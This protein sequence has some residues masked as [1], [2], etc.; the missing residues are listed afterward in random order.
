MKDK[1]KN[2]K[3]RN[4]YLIGPMGAGK[5][6]VGSRLA[7][8]LK[9]QFYDSDQVIEQQT[10][11]DI[12]WIYDV[13]GED[14]FQRREIK[15]IADLTKLDCILLST[16]GGSVMSQENRAAL[17]GNGV[18]IYLKTSLDNQM[19]RVKR[20]K[21]RPLVNES[22]E[23][24]DHLRNLRVKLGV[25]YEDLADIVYETDG[26]SLYHVVSDIVKILKNQGLI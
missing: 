1:C 5:T 4:I 3:K 25:F 17:K 22:E 9:L 10:G 8:K 18:V 15:V 12:P 6:S 20:S 7:K 13:E 14:G 16:G 24:R 11:A 23:R 19:E 21:K 26:K 2:S